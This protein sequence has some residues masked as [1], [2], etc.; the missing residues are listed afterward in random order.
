MSGNFN[1]TIRN[2]HCTTQTLHSK[3]SRIKNI[4]G[5]VVVAAVKK[6]KSGIIF[7]NKKIRKPSNLKVLDNK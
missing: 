6:N 4:P 2:N 1:L 7:F 5:I 3:L